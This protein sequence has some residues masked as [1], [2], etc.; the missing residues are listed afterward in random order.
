M[1]PKVKRSEL[2]ALAEFHALDV[3]KVETM[4]ELVDARP[5]RAEGLRFLGT[6]LRIAGVLSLAAGLVFFVAANWSR[7]AVFGRFA[8]VELVLIACVAIAFVK[9]PPA[10]LGRG[11]AFLAFIATGALLALFGQTY[12]TGADI[13][14]LF[15][16]WA[17][18]GLPL[19]VAAQWSVATAAWVLVLNVALML[20]CGWNPTGGLLWSIFGGMQ[21]RPAHLVM[22]AAGLNLAL[23][24]AFEFWR[25]DAVPDWVRRWMLSCAFGF[26]TWG[27]VIAVTSENDALAGLALLAA[28]VG[29]AAYAMRRRT[30]V[31]PLAVVMGTFI[32]VSLVWLGTKIT[33]SD[34]GV[35]LLMALWLIGTSTAAG[36]ILTVLTRRWRAQVAA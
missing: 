30:D 32:I 14:E 12:Q 4:L 10:N 24:F 33:F 17:L 3:R 9:P 21:F 25:F 31:Y 23:W 6:C 18:L 35:F 26:G 2:D 20:F 34:E 7:F 15:L 16:T 36:R 28:I 13:Y 11:A 22:G 5:T 27:G 19:A 29:V 1:Q 8:L